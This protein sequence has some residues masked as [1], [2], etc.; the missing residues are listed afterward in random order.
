MVTPE[1]TVD[2][3][4]ESSLLR[5]AVP[6]EHQRL[7]LLER[8][9]DSNT[10]RILSGLE[11]DPAWQCLELG[12]GAGSI[13]R[14]LAQQCRRVTATDNDTSFLDDLSVSNLVVR[15]HDVVTGD[16]PPAS[17]DLVH[18]RLLLEHL[19][20]RD[21]VL[22]KA[23][24][25]LAPGGWL[26][27]EDL[28]VF[29]LDSSPYPEM[30]QL[31]KAGEQF[32]AMTV[33][34]DQRWAPRLPTLLANAGLV[35]V[36]MSVAVQVFDNGPWSDFVRANLTQLGR[37]LVAAGLLTEDGLAAATA[38]L[39]DPSYVDISYATISVWGRC[40]R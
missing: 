18:A 1:N 13:A 3:R 9:L 37:A 38:T 8:A 33:G 40:P 10:I 12:A 31:W 6:T 14:W 28:A 39:D 27:I 22:A 26:V 4:Y 23:A 25:W 36:G 15:R 24:G 5:H 2:A 34:T 16:F 11:I 17:F 29:P 20:E 35:E 30:R 32:M 7:K 21:A 19:R